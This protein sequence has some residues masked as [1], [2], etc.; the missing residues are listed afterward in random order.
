MSV[1]NTDEML[2]QS[3]DDPID[4]CEKLEDYFD[5]KTA[6]DIY[7]YLKL[8]G[9]YIPYRN[10]IETVK[11]LQKKQVWQIV[12]DEEKKL[13]KIWRGPNIPIFIFLAD[14]NNRKIR[15]EFNGKSG[16]AFKDKLFLFLSKT[17]TETEIKAL[18]THEYHHV[19]RVSAYAKKEKDYVLLD[20]IIMEGLAEQA[21]YERYGKKYMASWTTYY[22]EN[23]LSEMWRKLVRPNC[24]LPTLHPKHNTLLYGLQFYPNMLG[25]CVGYYLVKKYQEERKLTSKQ[26]LTINADEFAKKLKS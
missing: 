16:I 25:Y 10:G 19:C 6:H 20:S 21:V 18:L 9:M 5:G 12:S 26:L 4:I 24:Q 8:H 14:G 17:N 3:F 1:I 2:L 22:T 15:K 23:E 13:R 7:Q 11:A